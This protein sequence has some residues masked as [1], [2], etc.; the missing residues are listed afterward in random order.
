M[1]NINI[2]CITSLALLNI[3]NMFNNYVCSWLGVEWGLMA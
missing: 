3:F 2:T 1:N